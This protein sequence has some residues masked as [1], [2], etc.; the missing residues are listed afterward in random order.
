MESFT[1]PLESYG[2]IGSSRNPME[3]LWDHMEIYADPV[4]VSW[5][6]LESYGDPMGSIG[7]PNS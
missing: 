6:S 7:N 1:N 5:R 2:N 4:E 3:L